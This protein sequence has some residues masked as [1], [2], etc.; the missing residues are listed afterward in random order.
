MLSASIQL[1]IRQAI[2]TNRWA[3]LIRLHN[4]TQTVVSLHVHVHLSSC[5]EEVQVIPATRTCIHNRC[6][7]VGMVVDGLAT[8]YC[9]YILSENILCHSTVVRGYRISD[10]N[11]LP[12]RAAFLSS[13]KKELSWV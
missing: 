13:L 6:V 7:G 4:K 3:R 8:V 10:L 9:S 1:I 12:A 5:H 2:Q 11:P